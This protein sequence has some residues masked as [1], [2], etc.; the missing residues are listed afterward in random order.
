MKQ[1]EAARAPVVLA[2]IRQAHAGIRFRHTPENLSRNLGALSGCGVVID[3]RDVTLRL[4]PRRDSFHR[5][6]DDGGG[7]ALKLFRYLRPRQESTPVPVP[8]MDFLYYRQR[9]RRGIQLLLIVS[10]SSAVS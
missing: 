7:I 3:G 8:E 6:H 9:H 5:F 2:S 10:H 4:S 1:M